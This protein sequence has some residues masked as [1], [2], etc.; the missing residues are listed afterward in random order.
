MP[1]GHNQLVLPVR[2]ASAWRGRLPRLAAAAAIL[3]VAGMVAFLVSLRVSSINIATVTPLAVPVVATPS[4]TPL[5]LTDVGRMALGRVVTIQADRSNDEALGTGWLFD[6]RGDFVTNAHVVEGQL[7]V[8]VTDR[9]AHTFVATVIGVDTTADIALIRLSGGYSGVPLPVDRLAI[10][11]LPVPVVDLASS[12]ATGHDDITTAVISETGQ[13]VPL[14]QGEVQPGSA[15]PALYHDM[16]AISGAQVY[17]GNS[18]GPVLNAQ[19]QVVGI[20]TLA[21]P[22]GPNAYAIPITRVFTE[23]TQY[24]ATHG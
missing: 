17:E 7:T 10:T 6:A 2:P 12:R 24:A 21:S 23:L 5:P 20:L 3:A 18:G 9:Q 15:A 1:V 4:A 16:L 13:D 11:T 8:R 14:Q 22:S 19:G